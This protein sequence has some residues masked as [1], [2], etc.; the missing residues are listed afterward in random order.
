MNVVAVTIGSTGDIQP[1]LALGC[2]LSKAG[3]KLTI[4]TFPRFQAL[5][6]KR[7]FSFAPIHGDEDLMMKLLI[8]DGVTGMAYMKGLSALLNKNKDEILDDVYNACRSADLILYTILGSLAY[9]VAESLKIPCMRTI[10]CPMDKTGDYPIP[11][12]KDWP[13]GR[14]YNRLTYSLS[15]IG[16]SLFT[17][18]ELNAWRISLGL[19]KWNGRSYH[20]MLGKPVETLYAYSGCL[21]PKPKVWGEH[22]HITGFWTLNDE[23]VASADEGLVRFLKDGDKPIYIGFGSM[24]GGSFEEM[25]HIILESLKNTGQRA[26]LSSGWRKFSDDKLPPNVYCVDFVPHGW[27]FPRVKAVVHHGGAGTTAAGLLAGKPTLIIHF[28]G[29]QP[30]WGRQVYL[31][32]AGPKPI[33]RKKL[34]L[35]L[36]TERLRQ[37]E[38]EQMQKTARQLAKQLSAEDGCQRACDI[39]E[40][41]LRKVK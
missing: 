9:H 29:D 32:G 12:M 19:G 26:I 4:V 14:W 23:A 25:Q 39:I 28:G 2:V 10:F 7:G 5:I 20:E 1:F 37:L 21:A 34:T 33:A 30:F 36:L 40:H 27:L 3:H 31:S 41:Y 17:K 22:L 35:S 18:Q 15:D 24:V 11:G 6:E 8:G 16:F 13:L 38:D